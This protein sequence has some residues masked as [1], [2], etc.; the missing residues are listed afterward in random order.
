MSTM[1]LG[2]QISSPSFA[3]SSSGTSSSVP[4][5]A[6]P[7]DS[8]QASSS[9]ILS[10]Q[11][12]LFATL[13]LSFS[14]ALLLL[15]DLLVFSSWLLSFH[16]DLFVSALS[17]NSSIRCCFFSSTDSFF[18]AFLCAFDSR[19]ASTCFSEKNTLVGHS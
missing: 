8:Q 16:F 2:E 9:L 4:L 13:L 15:L 6:P 10:L 11:L 14:S 5:F 7:S 12:F 1:R 17:F 19:C 3:V 18:S